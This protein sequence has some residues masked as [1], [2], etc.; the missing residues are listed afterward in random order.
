MTPG[1]VAESDLAGVLKS[2]YVFFDGKR[3]ARRDLP[4]G[5]VSYYFSDQLRTTD[6]VT[7]ALG[8]I[9][10]ESDFYPWGGELQFSANDS[11]HY[12]FTGKERDGETGLDYFGARY[13]ANVLGR[14]ISADP[15]NSSPILS[16]L[17]AN[18]QNL[19]AYQYGHNNPIIKSDLGGYLT[20]IVPGTW[21]NH[22]EWANSGFRAQVERR[23]TSSSFRQ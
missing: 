18:P 4:A 7:D 8:N 13:Y 9:K 17:I 11:N 3:V 15:I 19:N 14:F 21:N 6:I 16:K 10:N 12:K 20:I 1:I 22:S 23:G 5:A 2:E